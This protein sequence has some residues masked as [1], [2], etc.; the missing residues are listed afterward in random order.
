MNKNQ[1]KKPQVIQRTQSFLQGHDNHIS[2]IAISK[3]GKYMAS[4]YTGV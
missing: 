4:G 1:I 3:S 2:T